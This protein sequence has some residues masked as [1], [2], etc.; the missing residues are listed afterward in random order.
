MKTNFY[1]PFAKAIIA[2]LISERGKDIKKLDFVSTTNE[3]K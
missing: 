2:F 3:A 1:A